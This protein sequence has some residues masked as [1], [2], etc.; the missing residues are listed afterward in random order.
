MKL[1]IDVTKIIFKVTAVIV[2]SAIFS[3]DLCWASGGRFFVNNNIKSVPQH[4]S[5]ELRISNNEFANNFYQKTAGCKINAKTIGGNKP[6]G[7]KKKPE[8]HLLQ[9]QKKTHQQSKPKYSKAG[10]FLLYGAVLL[11]TAF[12]LSAM[13]YI[14]WPS[15]DLFL[16]SG[17]TPLFYIHLTYFVT[18][19][20]M[21]IFS[22][23]YGIN[24]V[25]M[26][27]KAFDIGAYKESANYSKK[28][29]DNLPAGIDRFPQIAVS[30]PVFNEDN[31]VVIPSQKE[32]ITVVRRYNQRAGYLAA[33]A[34][35]SEDF[36]GYIGL[37]ASEID[38][39]YQIALPKQ[40]GGQGLSIE[41]MI[42]S[43]KYFT[44]TDTN[45][46]VEETNLKICQRIYFYAQYPNEINFI[47]RKS[48]GARM[49]NPDAANVFKDVIAVIKQQVGNDIWD[50]YKGNEASPVDKK[51]AKSINR[52]WKKILANPKKYRLVPEIVLL[53]EERMK[54]LIQHDEHLVAFPA[55]NLMM[56]L[57]QM[58]WRIGL[59][60]KASNL[61]VGLFL[62]KDIRDYQKRGLTYARSVEIALAKIYQ[63]IDDIILDTLNESPGATYKEKYLS[64]YN[65]V[66][67]NFDFKLKDVHG[68]EL[69]LQEQAKVFEMIDSR[70]EYDLVNQ[71]ERT[72]FKNSDITFAHI[73]TYSFEQTG[74]VY[75]GGRNYFQGEYV[76]QLDKD[77]TL[78]P[79]LLYRAIDDEIKKKLIETYGETA[80]VKAYENPEYYAAAFWQVREE[81]RQKT[82]NGQL[83]G[84]ISDDIFDVIYTR[85]MCLLP[86]VHIE[87][88]DDVL[89]AIFFKSFFK[90]DKAELLYQG[91]YA[92][93]TKRELKKKIRKERSISG[94]SHVQALRNLY[95]KNEIPAELYNRII[96]DIDNYLAKDDIKKHNKSYPENQWNA[97]LED[98]KILTQ[99]TIQVE[100]NGIIRELITKKAQIYQDLRNFGGRIN[101][102]TDAV[103]VNISLEGSEQWVDI[104]TLKPDILE[105]NV[106]HLLR[107]PSIGFTVNSTVTSNVMDNVVTKK[108]GGPARTFFSFRLPQMAYYG[109]LIYP[110]HNGAIVMKALERIG[111]WKH[112]ISEDMVSADYI[113]LL[114]VERIIID[115]DVDDNTEIMVGQI[116][117]ALQ[118]RD[119]KYTASWIELD[120]TAHKQVP[121][122]VDGE[123]ITIMELSS[124]VPINLELK[125]IQV[126]GKEYLVAQTNVN[127]HGK[128]MDFEEQSPGEECPQGSIE[129]FVQTIKFSQGTT[130]A[131]FNPITS[132]FKGASLYWNVISSIAAFG[133]VLYIF[134]FPFSPETVSF[135]EGSLGYEICAVLFSFFGLML[136][137]KSAPAVVKVLSRIM[138]PD[139]VSNKI[140]PDNWENTGEGGIFQKD[141]QRIFFAPNSVISRHQKIDKFLRQLSFSA[142]ILILFLILWTPI[143]WILGIPNVFAMLPGYL[144]FFG[145][146]GSFSAGAEFISGRFTDEVKKMFVLLQDPNV[147]IL[148]KLLNIFKVGVYDTG[149]VQLSIV[150][151]ILIGIFDWNIVPALFA[152]VGLFLLICKAGLFNY[153]SGK[154]G[155]VFKWMGLTLLYAGAV[156]Y[157]G[158]GA[159]LRIFNVHAARKATP[160]VT[161]EHLKP[162]F[163]FA[164]MLRILRGIFFPFYINRHKEATSLL[165][166]TY[167]GT[168]D[169]GFEL[170]LGPIKFNIGGIDWGLYMSAIYVFGM[171]TGTISWTLLSE[172]ILMP[173][174]LIFYATVV[175]PFLYNTA[176]RKKIHGWFKNKKVLRGC[177]FQNIVF[178]VVILS[179]CIGVIVQ[180]AVNSFSQFINEPR[181][182][183][184]TNSTQHMFS[185]TKNKIKILEEQIK[186]IE[187]EIEKATRNRV[188]AEMTAELAKTRISWLKTHEGKRSVE[189]MHAAKEKLVFAQR[190]MGMVFK[191]RRFDDSLSTEYLDEG[192]LHVPDNIE[193]A[194][195]LEVMLEK[196]GKREKYFI[197][198]LNNA[199][200][201][202][203]ESEAELSQAEQ[204]LE[205]AEKNSA[206]DEQIYKRRMERD[207][208][209]GIVLY[210]QNAIVNLTENVDQLQVNINQLLIIREKLK[211]NKDLSAQ[212][213]KFF[214][215]L[216]LG[217]SFNVIDA[218]EFLEGTHEGAAK[219]ELFSEM[220]QRNLAKAKQQNDL[221]QREIVKADRILLSRNP[222]HMGLVQ[223][224]NSMKL[225]KNA[226]L[227]EFQKIKSQYETYLIELN[228]TNRITAMLLADNISEYKDF[229]IFGDKFTDENGST[230]FEK[231]KIDLQKRYQEGQVIYDTYRA[232]TE[233]IDEIPQRRRVWEEKVTEV[234]S[235]LLKMEGYSITALDKIPYDYIITIDLQAQKAKAQA[236]LNEELVMNPQGSQRAIKLQEIITLLTEAIILEDEGTRE[237]PGLVAVL[238][239][240]QQSVPELLLDLRKYK[241]EIME[242]RKQVIRNNLTQ[243]KGKMQEVKDVLD[244]KRGNAFT[245]NAQFIQRLEEFYEEGY[246]P[247]QVKNE[248][249]NLLQMLQMLPELIDEAIFAEDNAYIMKKMTPMVRQNNRAYFDTLQQAQ[250]KK[251]KLDEVLTE[252]NGLIET[253]AS[254][255]KMQSQDFAEEVREDVTKAVD[256]VNIVSDVSFERAS[257]K[258]QRES[259]EANTRQLNARKKD[260][261]SALSCFKA[262]G[263]DAVNELFIRELISDSDSLRLNQQQTQLDSNKFTSLQIDMPQP[264]S[265]IKIKARIIQNMINLL[266]YQI[267]QITSDGADPTV[268]AGL[269]PATWK[270]VSGDMIIAQKDTPEYKYFELLSQISLHE[271]IKNDIDP[272]DIL[273]SGQRIG[274]KSIGRNSGWFD[275]LEY[276]NALLELTATSRQEDAL[277]MNKALNLLKEM[278][279]FDKELSIQAR[280][281]I[282]KW[283]QIQQKIDE[284]NDLEKQR[285]NVTDPDELVQIIAKLRMLALEKDNLTQEAEDIYLIFQGKETVNIFEAWQARIK[286]TLKEK[287]DYTISHLKTDLRALPCEDRMVTKLDLLISILKKNNSEFAEQANVVKDALI[288]ARNSHYTA[289]VISGEMFS[290]HLLIML[291]MAVNMPKNKTEEAAMKLKL[292]CEQL[293][294]N[295]TAG[296]AAWMKEIRQDEITRLQNLIDAARKN[297]PE[298]NQ[299]EFQALKI[300]EKGLET[301]KNEKASSG[302]E[303]SPEIE[304]L[305]ARFHILID[306]IKTVKNLREEHLY[307]NNMNK[308]MESE[309][310]LMIKADLRYDLDFY[311]IDKLILNN[312]FINYAEYVSFVTATI[313]EIKEISKVFGNHPEV[314]RI[315]YESNVS[316]YEKTIAEVTEQIQS[317]ENEVA[318]LQYSEKDEGSEVLISLSEALRGA[319]Y[320]AFAD[321]IYRVGSDTDFVA[322]RELLI[323]AIFSEKICFQDF[324]S[325]GQLVDAGE[326]NN[327]SLIIAR[328]QTKEAAGVRMLRE[329]EFDQQLDIIMRELRK[330]PYA[331]ILEKFTRDFINKKVREKNEELRQEQK[332][333]DRLITDVSQ[334]LNAKPV[335]FE[336]SNKTGLVDIIKSRVA[337]ESNQLKKEELK[338]ILVHVTN[339]KDVRRGISGLENLIL[340]VQSAEKEL[341]SFQKNFDSASSVEREKC[342]QMAKEKDRIKAIAQGAVEKLLKGLIKTDITILKQW[343]AAHGIVTTEVD[344]AGVNSHYQELLKIWGVDDTVDPGSVIG[345]AGK[346]RELIAQY[347][348]EEAEFFN[349]LAWKDT[350]IEVDRFK[351]STLDDEILK[352][353]E[354]TGSARGNK[355]YVP[356]WGDNFFKSVECRISNELMLWRKNWSNVIQMHNQEEV[357]TEEQAVRGIVWQQ[358]LLTG[359]FATTED[360]PQG[361]LGEQAYLYNQGLTALELIKYAQENSNREILPGI[362]LID[363]VKRLFNFFH[364]DYE[365]QIKEQGQFTG[366]FN[367]YMIDGR[368]GERQKE[369][370]PNAWLLKSLVFY[371]EQ[372]QDSSFQ[373]MENAIAQWLLSLQQNNGGIYGGAEG[374]QKFYSTEHQFSVYSAFSDIFHSAG[375]KKY[376]AAAGNIM[377]FIK[378]YLWNDSEKRFYAG[379]D[380]TLGNP[381][382][383]LAL[384]TITWA[385]QLI[386]PEEF[387]SN[388]TALQPFL[389]YAEKF[390]VT[391]YYYTKYDTPIPDKNIIDSEK[392]S[393][394]LDLLGV[395]QVEICGFSPVTEAAAAGKKRSV[396]FDLTSQMIL[397]YRIVYNFYKEK[398]DKET[399]LEKKALYEQASEEYAALIQKYHNDLEQAQTRSRNNP[400]A[401]GLP[402]SSS[403]GISFGGWVMQPDRLHTS[404][405]IMYNWEKSCFNPFSLENFYSVRND[406]LKIKLRGK[407]VTFDKNGIDQ[408]V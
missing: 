2:I 323:D 242:Q 373:D 179:L 236:M 378:Q 238:K 399:V 123:A 390:A 115:P 96:K 139:S 196:A 110:G 46:T 124:G 219:A 261:E 12:S 375:N 75:L 269:F 147:F 6:E 38:K 248:Y 345:I 134:A 71:F 365:T 49:D 377:K 138:L 391:D 231:L 50:N 211:E 190:I 406:L 154:P 108:I 371:R 103:E 1:K 119:E 24:A 250:Q 29:W 201:S 182:V 313:N 64:A 202:L 381:D 394:L 349:L 41:H 405:T 72:P 173:T 294:E 40:Y 293:R 95:T 225:E 308:T 112:F 69:T 125:Y 43:L 159:L 203:S 363:Q 226:L 379:R 392:R 300:F 275:C 307:L 146:I 187:E 109:A 76:Y 101:K 292:L 94:C 3:F 234:M 68:N 397:T 227:V 54:S 67:I 299:E 212:D 251:Q 209:E 183:S 90:K 401:Y 30:T 56:V 87:K 298:E 89:K 152:G 143:M 60:P 343:E 337:C 153:G 165:G 224:L 283:G 74:C 285:N 45:L 265:M 185:S 136:I 322:K 192:K 16:K 297:L 149:I 135:S 111:M 370:G 393:R 37:T 128:F 376:Q 312:K 155:G 52:A 21:L 48:R 176:L 278:T 157:S 329:N 132:W 42:Q 258:Y 188:I 356:F 80:G 204:N 18:M 233:R 86:L 396:D 254:I 354:T 55:R 58:Y 163:T 73:S 174:F 253:I 106:Q 316:Q 117:I 28:R 189:A 336:N 168:K 193:N 301:L 144:F 247:E 180:P 321:R 129:I 386:G 333:I 309:Q 274:S 220:I 366:F 11:L 140:V 395:S 20:S 57:G 59:F 246:I 235:L 79:E 303:E 27:Q 36:L 97:E 350:V 290:R 302:S 213:Y 130:E 223:R 214:N 25:F 175:G 77:S 404:A 15:F 400:H 100:T 318:D 271:K 22:V 327:S 113:S 14:A 281:L 237:Q 317:L 133:W 408:G 314:K 148:K 284:Y 8:K 99:L 295:E 81:N 195:L 121:V 244:K 277:T 167:L 306:R 286:K 78:M 243:S 287:I 346:L 387:E 262:A 19:I 84:S 102:E 288:A 137:F 353:L 280:K 380:Y 120:G 398:A 116:R 332:T 206:A 304:S 338:K 98:E 142:M 320:H 344:Q 141:F 291:Q 208:L 65:N 341:L 161:G 162:L 122:I 93:I 171:L 245:E 13:T 178:S 351:R 205:F 62:N 221:A 324:T 126:D 32:V 357:K 145:T 342:I 352:R 311:T 259:T 328:K 17:A 334:M 7:L 305:V 241:F 222:E 266:N 383:R 282:D 191:L 70:I 105:L 362:T 199:V 210:V 228:Q 198:E 215:M 403:W 181:L 31:S 82:L 172:G 85:A 347:V 34:I 53:I 339:V 361:Q 47:V 39:L 104:R 256:I 331:P 160:I 360:G 273:K 170:P 91:A 272:A 197:K 33:K 131:T 169:A 10:S 340:Q 270:I 92:N 252:I 9:K 217:A 358:D 319:G 276:L 263:I 229:L 326:D 118:L 230:Y 158:F 114:P 374:H 156:P 384:D 255:L 207:K 279:G 107:D 177:W 35:I 325:A 330:E 389:S 88:Q 164:D 166:S 289:H 23:C 372:T 310:R 66:K 382:S 151:A 296:Y 355:I 315:F 83:E 385:I 200:V 407:I 368:A 186:T 249:L 184:D 127:Y 63:Q 348:F 367:M 61:N 260:L 335:L 51:R 264:A 239:N 216:L 402:Q 26:M 364:V 388:F 44:Q 257:D 194:E 150:P 240:I 267:A 232:I 218:E 4:L 268:S 5:P 369:A 359:L